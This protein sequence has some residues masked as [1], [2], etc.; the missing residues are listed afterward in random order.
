MNRY[1]YFLQI[2]PEKNGVITETTK[3]LKLPKRLLETIIERG[4]FK[5]MEE[6]EIKCKLSFLK[7]KTF[8]TTCFSKQWLLQEKLAPAIDILSFKRSQLEPAILLKMIFL[9][10]NF[11]VF[12]KL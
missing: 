4:K 12:A 9:A 8:G 2:N 1:D 7:Q 5:L 11:K 10:G 3:A 6:E